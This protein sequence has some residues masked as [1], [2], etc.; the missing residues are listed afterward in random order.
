MK[1]SQE[2]ILQFIRHINC[3][4]KH[5]QKE[6]E[7][8]EK[9]A[10]LYNKLIVEKAV[11]KKELENFKQNKLVESVK[12]ITRKIRREKLVCDYFK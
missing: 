6:I 9:I 2:E 4:I 3:K 1:R 8:D 11:F 10:E 12:K 5:F 7:N